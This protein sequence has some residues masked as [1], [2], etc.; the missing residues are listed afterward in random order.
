MTSRKSTRLAALA[1]VASA[2][3]IGVGAAAAGPAE[4]ASSQPDVAAGTSGKQYVPFET[5]FGMARGAPGETVV[6]PAKGPRDIAPRVIV[7]SAGL[8]WS[9]VALGV[10][11]GFGLASLAAGAA[12]IVRSRRGSAV[13][14]SQLGK[15]R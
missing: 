11:F 10:G 2:A 3:L 7:S 14:G 12:L 13:A 9:D 5:D 1:A 8:D 15:A 4:V 6:M